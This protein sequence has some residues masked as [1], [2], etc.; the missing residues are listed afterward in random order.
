MLAC[1]A[2]LGTWAKLQRRS[3]SLASK[4]ASRATRSTGQRNA[5]L[6]A[7]SP[8]T[9]NNTTLQRRGRALS[10]VRT[11]N[12]PQHHSRRNGIQND[13]RQPRQRPRKHLRRIHPA[14]DDQ[15]AVQL[16]QHLLGQQCSLTGRHAMLPCH[17][18]QRVV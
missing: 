16:D 5:T 8:A 17:A 1:N 12:T 3:E 11:S 13:A 18:G 2:V 7:T 6:E 9:I 4:H 15:R 10:S 14:C